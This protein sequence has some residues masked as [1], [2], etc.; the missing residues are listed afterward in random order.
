MILWNEVWVLVWET[1]PSPSRD[2][3]VAD[4]SKWPEDDH[5]SSFAPGYW[6]SVQIAHWAAVR[7]QITQPWGANR[8]TSPTANQHAISTIN[9]SDKQQI[10]HRC[11]STTGA[12]KTTFTCTWVTCTWILR[13]GERRSHFMHQWARLSKAWGESVSGLLE[14]RN[15]VCHIYFSRFKWSR[16]W[17][18]RGD[19][20]NKRHTSTRQTHQD[21]LHKGRVFGWQTRERFT[22][23]LHAAICSLGSALRTGRRPREVYG[24]TTGNVLF[25]F[26]FGDANLCRANLTLLPSLLKA[27]REGVGLTEE[28]WVVH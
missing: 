9:S 19:S 1:W 13:S 2:T 18:N 14:S 12:L 23:Y 20:G 16:T 8:I 25:W 10:L 11:A 17:L 7:S 6:Q 28:K 4:D 21:T 15:N 3:R 22:V 5:R 24:N 27:K 26:Q